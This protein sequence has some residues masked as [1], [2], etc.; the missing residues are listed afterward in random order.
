MRGD[1]PPSYSSYGEIESSLRGLKAELVSAGVSHHRRLDYCIQS[2]QELIAITHGAPITRD[3]PAYFSALYESAELSEIA[4]AFEIFGPA[5]VHRLHLATQGSPGYVDDTAPEGRNISFELAMAVRA[6]KCGAK[7]QLPSDGDLTIA[8]PNEVFIAECKRPQ[9][10]ASLK[11]NIEKASRQGTKRTNNQNSIVMVDAS[12]AL[13]P[14]FRIKKTNLSRTRF[15]N[16]AQKFLYAFTQE[17]ACRA[18]GMPD[19][20]HIGILIRYSCFGVASNEMFHCQ[21]WTAYPNSRL[22]VASIASLRRIVAFFDPSYT[23]S[24]DA[25]SNVTHMSVY[26]GYESDSSKS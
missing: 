22:G 15:F 7:I 2:M 16:R 8:T 5:A 25:H 18:N 14:L 19:L 4:G 23:D 3:L 26:S 17:E 10:L 9:S 6:A 20:S 13:N 24:F 1:V 12:F 21:P 11:R